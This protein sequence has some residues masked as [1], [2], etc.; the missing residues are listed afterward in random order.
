MRLHRPTGLAA[1][2]LGLVWLLAS[3]CG[4]TRVGPPEA[5]VG[6]TPAVIEVDFDVDA[7]ADPGAKADC[8]GRGYSFMG[9]NYVVEARIRLKNGAVRRLPESGVYNE[10]VVDDVV[11]EKRSYYAP[12]G[13]QRLIFTVK[14][15]KRYST[16]LTSSRIAFRSCYRT[17][18]HKVVDRNFAA[19]RVY[20]VRVTNKPG[21]PGRR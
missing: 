20:Q 18:V 2:L 15:Q 12:T 9:Q 14:L 4:P 6:D 7:K 1:I 10:L 8:L 11:R 21:R 19:S 5:A 17:L 13:A 16:G 3:A